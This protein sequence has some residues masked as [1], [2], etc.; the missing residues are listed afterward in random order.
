VC[1]FD[2]ADERACTLV[3][4]RFQVDIVDRGERQVE[5]VAR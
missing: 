3:D 4:E 1:G 2:G 5:Q